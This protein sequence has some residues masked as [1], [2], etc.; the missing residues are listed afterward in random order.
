MRP[1]NMRHKPAAQR[2]CRWGD[3]NPHPLTRTRP[4][5]V[6][7]YQFRHTDGWVRSKYSGQLRAL[8]SATRA[9]W[10]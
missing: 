7:V 5:T 2:W 1:A 3:L 10:E 4:S 9:R 8:V 6:R